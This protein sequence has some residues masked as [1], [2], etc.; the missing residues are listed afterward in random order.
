MNLKKFVVVSAV[1]LVAALSPLSSFVGSAGGSIIP[2]PTLTGTYAGEMIKLNWT[3]YDYSQSGWEGYAVFKVKAGEQN[4]YKKPFA[5]LK[6]ENNNYSYYNLGGMK[7]GNYT[8][9]VSLYDYDIN[10]LK[11]GP[12]SNLISVT[13]PKKEGPKPPVPPA[14]N[15]AVKLKITKTDSKVSASWSA[16][17]GTFDGYVLTLVEVGKNGKTYDQN[18]VYYYLPKG[19]TSSDNLDMVAGRKYQLQVFPYTK[20]A[21]GKT[22][23][24]VKKA[25][26]NV[27]KVV[28][29]EHKIKLK[30]Y[31]LVA[32]HTVVGSFEAKNSNLVDGYA[33]YVV[34]GA[35]GEVSLD[36]ASPV[37]IGKD[38]TT[39]ELKGLTNG[40]YTVKVYAY[41]LSPSGAKVYHQPGSNYEM[42]E[43][44]DLDDL[45]IF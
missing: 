31:N 30:L 43:V 16:Y 4:T 27:K 35:Q 33:V 5:L 26:S 39:F 32:E 37:F 29:P 10:G 19:T 18:K 44:V 38:K 17:A 1:G 22:L 28:I 13:V 7:E 42:I 21:D 45:E 36:H 41:N 11:F 25:E 6:F 8:W 3:A 40:V 34:T 12:V 9:A 2:A 15:E 14:Q 20:N 23:T 24:Y